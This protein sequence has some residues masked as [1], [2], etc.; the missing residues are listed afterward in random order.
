MKT[1]TAKWFFVDKCVDSKF[2]LTG[3]NRTACKECDLPIQVK[4]SIANGLKLELK[5]IAVKIACVMTKW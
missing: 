1:V 2:I 4:C 5:N 3:P